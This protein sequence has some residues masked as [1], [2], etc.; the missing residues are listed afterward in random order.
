MFFAVSLNM[1][2]NTEP[3]C[4]TLRPSCYD[5][6]TLNDGNIATV[7]L[8]KYVHNFVSFCWGYHYYDVIM[9]AMGS[10][11]TKLTTVY[12]TLYCGAEQRKHQSSA[13]L[14]FM[15]AI[16]RRPV[17]SPHNWSVTRKRFPFDDVIMHSW[18]STTYVLICSF[19]VDKISQKNKRFLARAIM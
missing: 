10:Q 18:A 19:F 6:V 2:L 11:I 1:I 3:S 12:S 5:A 14:A 15:R 17:N 16:H 4:R 13:S 9:G 7:Y 8:M